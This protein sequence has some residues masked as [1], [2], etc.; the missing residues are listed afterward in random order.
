MIDVPS[1]DT[2]IAQ[3]RKSVPDVSVATTGSAAGAG[4]SAVET[5]PAAA[6]VPPID[7]APRDENE[8]HER[9]GRC[10]CHTHRVPLFSDPGPFRRRAGVV[11]FGPQ[12]LGAIALDF[13][14]CDHPVAADLA[15][16]ERPPLGL[17][18][19]RDGGQPEP[20]SGLS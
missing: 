5:L 12:V 18:A 6:A 3:L 17:D 9:E 15:G 10:P 20:F 13:G 7:V 11:L 19:E 8:Q 4:I 16:L 2:G 1:S 14:G